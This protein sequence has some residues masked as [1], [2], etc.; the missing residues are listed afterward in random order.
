MDPKTEE[1]WLKCRPEQRAT[2]DEDLC[3]TSPRAFSS[4][5]PVLVLIL[6]ALRSLVLWGTINFGFGGKAKFGGVF[7][8]W[9]FASPYPL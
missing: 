7:A 8:V 9:M 6:V 1:P 5:T 3:R 2:A 4:G